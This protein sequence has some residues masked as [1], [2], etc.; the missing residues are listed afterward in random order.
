MW[1][2][3]I[4]KIP[5][6]NEM[7][8]DEFKRNCQSQTTEVNVPTA[9]PEQLGNTVSNTFDMLSNFEP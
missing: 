1:D 9:T 4:H 3:Y 7:T 2:Y 6:W 8:W 5:A